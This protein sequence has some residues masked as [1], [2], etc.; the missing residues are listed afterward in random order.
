MDIFFHGQRL[1]LLGELESGPWQTPEEFFAPFMNMQGAFSHTWQIVGR[2]EEIE[3]IV[4]GL[5]NT[6]TRAI[7]LTGT[8]G[9]GK[10]RILKQALETYQIDHQDTLVRFLSPG[11]ELTKK[12]LEDLGNRE[13]V[14]VVDD[15]HDRDDLQLLFQYTSI[16]THSTTIFLSFRPYGLD[17]IT[18]QASNFALT[19][20]RLM[21]V[22]LDHLAFDQVKQLAT[23]VLKAFNGQ[24]SAAKDIAHL[25]RDCTLATVIG[26]QIVAKEKVHPEL[27]K[28][29]D[30]FRKTLLM[31][32]QDTITGNI[33]KKGDP[34]ST[35][36]LL[37][38][39]ALIQPFHLDDEAIGYIAEEVENLHAPEVHRLIRLLT[40]AGV[41]FKRGG[42]YRIS[43]DLL[44]DHIIEESCIGQEGRSTGYA[45]QIW[46]VAGGTHY[47]HILLNLGKLDWRLANGDPS[48]S[49]LLDGV[50]KKLQP[51]REYADPYIGA[52]TA[53][54]YYQPERTLDFVE[55]HI[56]EKM[57][58]RD[59]P[60]IIKYAG[61]NLESLP[62][63]CEC[64]WEIGK[65]DSRALNQHPG[66]AIR[67]LSELCAV[68]P[69]K[70]L[71][72]NE[73]V[74]SFGLSLLQQPDS[75][76][77]VYTPFDILKGILRTEGNTTTS[78]QSAITFHPFFVRFDAVSALRTMVIDVA[79]HLLSSPDTKLAVLAAN[80]L[81]K[82]LRYPMGLHNATVSKSLRDNW[83]KEFVQTLKK[84]EKVTREGQI[85]PHVQI[86]LAH[87][88]SWHANYSKEKTS[89]VAKKIIAALPSSLEA[90]TTLA[91]RDGYG[92]LVKKV[93]YKQAQYKWNE[94]LESLV[95]D[96]VNAFSDGELLRKFIEE[97]LTDNKVAY[98]AIS[99]SSHILYTR[100]VQRSLPLAQATV[101]DTLKNQKSSTGEFA[102]MALAQILSNEHVVGQDAARQYLATDSFDLHTAVGR[103]YSDMK[104]RSVGY[105]PED[106]E[107]LKTILASMDQWVV[108]NAI[109]AVRRVI[110]NGY[111][112]LAIDL[113]KH[114]DFSVSAKVAD[115]ALLLFQLDSIP[116]RMLTEQD[117]KHFLQQLKQL[118]ELDGYWIES[119][120]ADVSE[121]YS[122]LA[123]RFFMDRVEYAAM[124]KDWGYR[125]C[126][127]GPYKHIPMRFRESPK[128][129]VLLQQVS[130]WMKSYGS[131]DNIFHHNASELFQVMFGPFDGEFI[132]LL[133][134]WVDKAT[135]EDIHVIGQILKD[136]PSEII[137]TQRPFVVH[138]LE[139][140]KEFGKESVEGMRKALLNAAIT[141][142]RSGTPGEPF[143]E[144][145]R[146][147]EEAEK[148]MA[149][150]PRFSPAYRL[151]DALKQHS[152][153]GIQSSLREREEFDE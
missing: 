85:N 125:S 106:I 122:I 51:M 93:D 115:E 133:Q 17:Y 100:L 99:M 142:L 129:N 66:H 112:K 38:I 35:R 12:S 29:E 54:A 146:M 98:G 116:F 36:K 43:P 33:G 143:P 45:E 89:P 82:S 40:D 39:L 127:H 80:F 19:D 104:T 108:L 23:Q 103:A 15:A 150:L 117:V 71:E 27:I 28:N 147:K 1:A 4:E 137:Y 65:N 109:G 52:V 76:N 153:W 126:N 13:T 56:G 67:I 128:F 41:L 92:H 32:F 16:P 148:A 105:T 135:S 55:Q 64:L 24:V 97:R 21:E 11:D 138:A 7:F 2:T 131:E 72:Y 121:H 30:I 84:I 14:L 139:K 79:I 113:L 31:R 119:F 81:E 134:D 47:K 26:A 3:R 9:T 83:T 34:E 140:A 49:Q 151:Y 88:V 120:L 68:E 149:E 101:E 61:Y 20:T 22:R 95:S 145:L 42:K 91:F 62:R 123:A 74:V 60:T 6:D 46:E 73:V 78:H 141:G 63:A 96:L 152:E 57:F 10:S 102:G 77:Q 44:A 107:I 69:N 18:A 144:D 86:E 59:M 87:S 50:W 53:V 124:N 70:P 25:T 111:Q 136:A 118:S 130:L 114:V 37:R 132:E 75:W 110:G 8:G 5:S 58:V 94:Y 48:N 90:R